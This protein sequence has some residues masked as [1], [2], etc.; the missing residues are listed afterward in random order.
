MGPHERLL[1]RKLTACLGNVRPLFEVDEGAQL[2]GLLFLPR[3]R[4]GRQELR[5]EALG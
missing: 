3:N 1:R 4:E 5:E 2:L